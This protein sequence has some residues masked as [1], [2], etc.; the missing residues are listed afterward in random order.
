MPA[1]V[2]NA[3]PLPFMGQK[4]RFVAQFREALQ[5]FPAATT[6]VDLFGGS[7]LLSHVVKRQR[8]DAR[9]VYNDFDDFHRRIEHVERT[10][11]IIAEIREVLDGVP[12]MKKVPTPKRQA[13]IEL[14]KQHEQ[15]EYVDYVTVSSSILFSG[16]YATNIREVEKQT[17]YNTTKRTPYN[18][19]GYLDGLEIVKADY[20]ELFAQYE[21]TP[22]VVFL[23]DPPYLATQTGHYE[24]YWRL[25]DYLDVFATIV[26]HP[27]FYFTSNKS[28]VIEFFDWMDAHGFG[29]PFKEAIRKEITNMVNYHAQYTDIMI[30][31]PEIT[32][33]ASKKT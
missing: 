9:V 26:R 20:R 16:N 7:G 24:N 25:A 28:S 22:G 8:P 1:K 10:N 19:D 29:S 18:C 31:R 4:R 15:I 12:R 27:F 32:M 30:Y 17:L 3:S 11:A 2:Y 23:V 5:E 21:N 6:F 33:S 14:L 13:I